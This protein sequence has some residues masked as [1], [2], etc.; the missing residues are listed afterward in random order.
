VKR[1]ENSV[2]V[3]VARGVEGSCGGMVLGAVVGVVDGEVVYGG[4]RVL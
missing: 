2:V 4:E 3:R 1:E